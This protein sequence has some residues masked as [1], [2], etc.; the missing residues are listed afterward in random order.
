M[1]EGSAD[2]VMVCCVCRMSAEGRRSNCRAQICPSMAWRLTWRQLPRRFA[3]SGRRAM[4]ARWVVQ[5][6]HDLL[7]L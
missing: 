5:M 2:K 6:R 3:A 7:A 4:A 1:T